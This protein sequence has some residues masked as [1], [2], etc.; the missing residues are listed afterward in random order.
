MDR[1]SFR[2]ILEKVSVPLSA[3]PH[4][5]VIARLFDVPFAT[6]FS[7]YSLEVQGRVLR[8]NHV[9]KG[10][11]QAHARRYL[12]GVDALQLAFELDFPPC[13][14][15]RRLLEELDIGLA[16]DRITRAFRQPSLLPTL[17]S[18][19]SLQRL[20][21]GKASATAVAAEGRL[22][23]GEEGTDA[24]AATAATA[25][26][27]QARELLA[28]LQRDI[29][30]CVMCDRVCSP[31]S[32]AIR[33]SAGNEYEERLNADLA[34]AGVAFWTEDQLRSRGYHKT[35]DARLQVPIAVRGR[36][37][38][39]IDSKA[40]FGDDKLHRQQTAEQYERYVN[41][42]GPGLV[43]YWHGYIADLNRVVEG[44]IP[45]PS[46][47]QVRVRLQLRPVNPADIFSVQGVYPGFASEEGSSLPAVPGLEGMGVVDKCG[48]GASQ[49]KAGQRVTGAPFDA[50]KGC[51]TWQQYVVVNEGQLLAVPDKV[52]DE[53]AAQFLINPV[54]LYGFFDVLKMPKGEYLLS[55]AASSTLGRMII[56]LGKHYGI[57]TINLVRSAHHVDDLKAL[58][59][60]EVIVTTEED[61]VERVKQIT[62]GKGAYA[63][64]ECVGGEITEQLVKATRN[65][66]TVVVYGAMAAFSFCSGVHDVLFRG[67]TI[68]GFW[69]NPYL[70]SVGNRRSEVLKEVMNLLEQ[71]TIS[72][73]SGTHYPLG[74][75]R[76]AIVETQTPKRGG[77]CFLEG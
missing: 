52:S 28:R 4:F 32:D 56:Q 27:H 33:H 8:R 13:V 40:T 59:A 66:G 1:A 61:L 51:G 63:T 62:G 46:K 75:A 76:Q 16:K 68:K 36:I 10:E 73:Y 42:F 71:G 29:E 58:G 39:W 70:T 21:A 49:F 31:A 15:L 18:L 2:A 9:V 25:D 30:Q 34:A 72:P 14:L 55:N 6:V 57:K 54:T 12:A 17:V 22:A 23:N 11:I 60:D 65:N 7:I 41:R 24:A 35:P 53:A 47:G 19:Q 44:S 50:A 69:L 48:A 37:V 64:L 20:A 77:K 67:V 5:E 43:I 38:N 45:E 74:E 3:W 26:M